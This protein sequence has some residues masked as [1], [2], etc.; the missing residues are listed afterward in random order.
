MA[1]KKGRP[2]KDMDDRKYPVY[3][4]IPINDIRLLDAIAKEARMTRSQ[5]VRNF[6]NMGLDDVKIMRKM[7]IIKAVGK[8]R[9]FID[10]SKA[11]MDLPI[12]T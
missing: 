5:L 3:I 6:I 12:G 10:K 11:Q 8:A 2:P 9:E 4:S 1:R 7:G